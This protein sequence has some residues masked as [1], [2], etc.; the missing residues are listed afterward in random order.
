MIN[1]VQKFDIKINNIASAFDEVKK[2]IAKNEKTEF[3]MDL[4]ALNIIDATKILVVS[5]AY[6][7]GKF[8][9]G[10]I[11]YRH[12]VQEIGHLLDNFSIKNLELV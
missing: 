3:S 5:S 10:K 11:K 4:S 2:Y 9:N 7:Y 1:S 6:L 8:P 12:E